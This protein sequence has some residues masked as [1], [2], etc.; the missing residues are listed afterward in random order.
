MATRNAILSAMQSILGLDE[1]ELIE[2][3]D[4]DLFESGLVDS[5]AMV[6]LIG[7]VEGLIGRR[8][9]IRDMSPEDFLS[10]NRLSAAIERQR[11]A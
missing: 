1:A 7:E 5:L 4:M 10:V 8:I 3:L 9:I 6:T 11:G 2:N